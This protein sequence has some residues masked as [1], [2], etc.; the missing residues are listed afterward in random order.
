M[1]DINIHCERFNSYY[2]TYANR[3]SKASEEWEHLHLK[4]EHS[5][6]VLDNAEKILAALGL[7]ENLTH[8]AR[9]AALYHDVARFEQYINYRTFRDGESA[10][11]GFWGSKIL[12]HENFLAGES[13]STIGLV[14]A[15]V[16]MHNRF[17]LPAGILEEYKLITNIVRDADKIDILRVL[18]EYMEPGK[19]GGAV[20]ANLPDE[21]KCWSPAVYN[22]VLAGRNANYNDMRY[23]NDFRLLIGSWI[24]AFNFQQSIKLVALQ[25]YWQQVLHGLPAGEAMN[26]AK[27]VLNKAMESALQA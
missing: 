15:A 27:L 23:L 26:K 13:A 6:K 12:K 20:T 10:N 16:S 8:A 21:P 19:Q 5:L 17:A 3:F 4:W 14:R 18:A 22:A 9:L 2:Q 7:P 1:I 24:Y 25:G 11:H